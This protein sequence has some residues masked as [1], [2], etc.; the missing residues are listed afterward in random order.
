MRCI[1]RPSQIVD[2]GRKIFRSALRTKDYRT[3][4][5]LRHGPDLSE[6]SSSRLGIIGSLQQ[7][8]PRQMM[9]DNRK[10]FYV[11][12]NWWLCRSL[13]LVRYNR[14]ELAIYSMMVHRPWFKDEIVSFDF[15]VRCRGWLIVDG[16]ALLLKKEEERGRAKARVFCR[17]RNKTCT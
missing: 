15:S 16:S 6:R 5:R 9:N 4:K 7:R 11:D 17:Q 13:S 12:T 10:L 8:S 1:L 3:W 2:H 14:N